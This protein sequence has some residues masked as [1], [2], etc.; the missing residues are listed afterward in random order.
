MEY[1]DHFLSDFN[2]LA[3][4]LMALAPFFTPSQANPPTFLIFEAVT[5]FIFDFIIPLV[6]F[7]TS[8]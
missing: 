7:N 3:P 4:D 2:I 5:F 6:F 1:F 8:L